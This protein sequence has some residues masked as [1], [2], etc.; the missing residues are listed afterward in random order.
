LPVPGLLVGCAHIAC[1]LARFAGVIFLVASFAHSFASV[2]ACLAARRSAF[3]NDFCDAVELPDW[4][5]TAFAGAAANT[6]VAN[7]AMRTD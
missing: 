5:D 3:A 4:M 6:S 2:R 1:R 7:A